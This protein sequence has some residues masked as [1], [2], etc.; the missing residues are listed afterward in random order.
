MSLAK[1]LTHTDMTIKKI[2]D[3]LKP[4]LLDVKLLTHLIISSEDGC[5]VMDTIIYKI[6]NEGI[7]DVRQYVYQFII[8]CVI[9]NTEP[10]AVILNYFVILITEL[11]TNPKDNEKTYNKV[12]FWSQKLY[13]ELVGMKK[14]L[15]LTFGDIIVS[16]GRAEYMDRYISNLTFIHILEYDHMVHHL[17]EHYNNLCELFDSIYLNIG[18][19]RYVTDNVVVCSEI[20]I[21]K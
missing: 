13:Y 11:Y 9:V 17:N 18:V 16:A 19:R 15:K 21:K 4:L 10:I 2:N 8:N 7:E 20:I 5:R 6:N 14:Q 3:I 1:L 12:I